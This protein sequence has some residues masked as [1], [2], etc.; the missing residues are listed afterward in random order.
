MSIAVVVAALLSAAPAPVRLPAEVQD[1]YAVR[2]NPAGLGRLAGP[3]LRLL[4]GR[5][6]SADLST[7]YGLGAY[8]AT[9]LLGAT[10]IAVGFESNVIDGDVASLLTLGL[11]AG[12]GPLS[13][14]VSYSKTWPRFGESGDF[15]TLGA[16]LRPVDYVRLGFA[17]RDLGQ[18]VMPRQY[19][20]GLAIQPFT[21]L[22]LSTRWRYEEGE[23]LNTD[24]LDLAFRAE[25]EPL[26]GL[27]VGALTDVD[28][29]VLLQ[30]SLNF[31]R[32]SAGG[33]LDINDGDAGFTTELVVRGHRLPSLRRP[34][35]VALMDLT[36][37]LQPAPIFSLFAGGF[38][39]VPYGGILFY[40]E[41]LRQ[42]DEVAGIFARIGPLDIGWGKAE[43]LRSGLLRI[44]GSGRRVDCELTGTD[45]K[46][47]FLA[48]A[49]S[50]I[51]MPPPIQLAVNGIQAKL[52]FVKEALDRYGIEAEVYRRDAYKTSPETFTKRGISPAQ[53]RS[54]GAYIDRVNATLIDGISKGRDLDRPYVE[55]IL[56]RGVVSSTEAV[57]LKLIDAVKYPDEVEKWVR[58]Q[59]SGGIVVARGREALQPERSTWSTPP[60]I[61]VIHIDA[62]IASGRSRRLPFGLGRSVGAQDVVETIEA[63]RRSHRYVAVVLRVD[64]PGGG[65]YASDIIARAV[66][67]LAKVKPV[68]ASF[69]DI[70]ASGGYYVASGARTI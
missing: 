19:D 2:F 26:Q 29:R 28:G 68:I 64:S 66:R 6:R 30:L 44:R 34:R 55:A 48:T 36:G 46:A 45:D 3:E 33:Q 23:P 61:A 1:A 56:Q 62:P 59:Y 70:A 15:W 57:A 69:G 58:S 24:T 9:R 7:D 49:C 13:F 67:K 37:N 25:I 41:R 14:G 42:D 38:K 10:S 52:L 43:E 32:L 51:V 39:S 54:L 11:G 8:A 65:A 47:Y 63:V 35:R 5:E 4:A 16:Q 50:A 40:L 12:R 22:T 20:T 21:R 31:E 53:R 17:M 18:T 60:A 27:Q